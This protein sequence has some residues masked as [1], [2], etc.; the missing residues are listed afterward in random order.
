MSAQIIPFPNRGLCP[1]MAYAVSTSEPE[2][3]AQ[4][5]RV[6][7]FAYEPDAREQVALAKSIFKQ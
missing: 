7:G 1:E 5:L 3:L 6:N 4:R 2:E